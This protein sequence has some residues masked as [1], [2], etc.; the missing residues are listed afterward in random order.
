MSKGLSSGKKSFSIAQLTIDN[1]NN[2]RLKDSIK[3]ELGFIPLCISCISRQGLDVSQLIFRACVHDCQL[4]FS[5]DVIKIFPCIL[6]ESHPD[7][8]VACC[9]G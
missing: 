1:L 2:L 8:Q 4:L 3:V 9:H 7:K 5:T 6:F